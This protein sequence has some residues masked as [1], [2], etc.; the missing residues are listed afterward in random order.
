MLPLGI[1]L[2]TAV[3]GTVFGIALLWVLTQWLK[4][5]EAELISEQ[6]VRERA[7]WL[8]AQAADQLRRQASA[9]QSLTESRAGHLR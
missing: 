4:A 8:Q 2:V 7:E 3:A 9:M 5:D 1:S 6:D